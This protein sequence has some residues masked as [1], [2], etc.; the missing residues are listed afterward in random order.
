MKYYSLQN[1]DAWKDAIKN[2]YLVG[3]KKYIMDEEFDAHYQWMMK[4][5][6]KRIN[7]DASDYPIW[8]W[9]TLNNVNIEEI[10]FNLSC[11]YVLLEIDLPEDKVLLSNFDAWHI[12]LNNG[13]FSDNI[14]N[15]NQEDDWETLFDKDTL[16]DE[17]FGFTFEDEDYQG[18]TGKINIE[19]ITVL[20][21]I[22][23]KI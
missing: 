20:K 21:Y 15:V 6:E 22:V 5:M 4:Q 7:V 18:V 11:D 16:E 10:T 13:Y 19:N 12:I 8:L 17:N 1:L 9:L 23:S 14:D 2:G 3:N